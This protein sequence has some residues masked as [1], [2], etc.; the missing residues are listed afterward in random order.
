MCAH[1]RLATIVFLSLMAGSACAT[2][3]TTPAPAAPKPA[4]T[5]RAVETRE[6]LASYYGERFHGRTTAS[7]RRFDMH[8]MVA[9]HPTYPFGTLLRVTN[10]ANNRSVRV[11]VIDRGPARQPRREGVIIDVSRG[12][13]EAL[14]FIRQGRTHV[15]L[16]VI[17]IARR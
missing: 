1:T 12:A 9:A 3:A 2:R 7:G 6:G 11:R 17:E 16:E 15:R 8:E 13:A 5:S 14:G 10:L 4:A